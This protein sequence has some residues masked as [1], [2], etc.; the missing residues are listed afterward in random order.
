ML[1][2]ASFV[3]VGS[4][5]SAGC[6][7][8]AGPSDAGTGSSGTGTDAGSGAVATGGAPTTEG[9]GPG[10]T[11]SGTTQAP[12]T[13]GTT[14]PGTGEAGE[15]G[16]ESGASTGGPGDPVAM[17]RKIRDLTGPG[18]SAGQWGVGGTDLGIPVRQPDGQIAYIFGDTFENDGVGGPGWRSPVLLR[19]APGGLAAGIEFTGAAG[20]AYA[21]QILDYEHNDEYSTWLPS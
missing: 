9:P 21:K 20:G 11:G 18:T 3:L 1:R 5:G 17:T 8:G 7:A 13:G 6:S 10:G 14:A 15:T 19:S 16:G 12:G 2:A 4:L